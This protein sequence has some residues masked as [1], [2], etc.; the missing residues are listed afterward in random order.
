MQAVVQ[1]VVITA[2]TLLYLLQ[3]TGLG[4][5]VWHRTKT[6][7]GRD[8]DDVSN[9]TVGPEPPLLQQLGA[10][11]QPVTDTSEELVKMVSALMA[12]RP[13]LDMLPDMKETMDQ[14]QDR[15]TNGVSMVTNASRETERS[16]MV[17]LHNDVV[18]VG[19]GQAALA[20][21]HKQVL[22]HT[23][24]AARL[25]KGTHGLEPIFQH[26][27]GVM[28]CVKQ[29]GPNLS[30]LMGGDMT[31]IKNALQRVEDQNAAMCTKINELDVK[32]NRA[33]EILEEFNQQA[34]PHA[35]EPSEV[36]P[37]H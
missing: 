11:L 30:R 15:L 8:V 28:Q 24:E 27:T 1:W 25:L 21:E 10:M 23:Q 13:H 12:K 7:L 35:Q 16:Q 18:D 34:T 31:E 22:A 19:K 4:A 32:L 6:F 17:T 3:V 36:E 33:L 29:L 2:I 5:K 37:S 14:I 20:A 26:I 9:K